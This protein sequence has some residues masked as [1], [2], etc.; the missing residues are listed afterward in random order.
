MSSS[1][2]PRKVIVR[3]SHE[4]AAVCCKPVSRARGSRSK[5]APPRKIALDRLRN[6]FIMI[7]YRFNFL[8][9]AHPFRGRALRTHDYSISGRRKKYYTHIPNRYR[10]LVFSCTACVRTNHEI[11][12]QSEFILYIFCTVERHGIMVYTYL[13]NAP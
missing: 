4:C 1:P 10:E 9:V 12:T 13:I 11:Q 7:L 3:P 2:S 8:G 5:S 6:E